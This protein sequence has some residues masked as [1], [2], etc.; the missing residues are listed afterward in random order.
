MSDLRSEI[1][2]FKE[3][4]SKWLKQKGDLEVRIESNEIE[5]TRR[6][7]QLESEYQEQVGVLT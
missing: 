7:V 2:Q 6:A 5:H 1:L 3:A 4:E